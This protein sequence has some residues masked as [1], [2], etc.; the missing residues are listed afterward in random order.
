MTIGEQIKKEFLS[1]IREPPRI[2]APFKWPGGKGNLVKW[3][4][5]YIPHGHIYVEPFAGAASV[6]WHLPKPFAV[7]VLNDLDADVINLYKV[8]KDSRKFEALSHK[9]IFTPYA[10]A[11]F[12][13]AI[14]MLKSAD[15]N[16]IDRAWAF[17][18][19]QNHGFSG[20]GLNESNWSR[21]LY[22]TNK[23]MAKNVSQWRSRLKI[24]SFWHKRLGKVHIY[25]LDAIQ[26]MKHWDTTDTVFYLDPPYILDTRKTHSIYKKELDL[27]YHERLVNTLLSVKGKVILSCYDHPTYYPLT[28]AGWQKITID[29]VCHMAGKNRGSKTRGVG[30][31][32]LYAS[33]CET[34]YVNFS[35]TKEETRKSMNMNFTDE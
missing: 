21:V 29:T 17:F 12:G 7:E 31:L 27:S 23:D 26:C 13:R 32:K 4:I 8:L 1:G 33:R 11:E 25:N 24:L 18:V 9:L 5:Q 22:C 2:M 19:R 3:I 10:R 35:V 6:F 34:L 16:D 28:E 30:N 15:I 14:Q 20:F